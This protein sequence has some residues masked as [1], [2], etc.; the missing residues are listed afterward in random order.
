MAKQKRPR[1]RRSPLAAALRYPVLLFT[2]TLLLPTTRVIDKLGYTQRVLTVIG[3]QGQAY[4]RLTR[5]FGSYTPTR[6]DVIVCAYFKSGTNWAMQIAHQIATRGRGEFN[7]IHDVIPWPDEVKR[8]YSIPLEDEAPLRASPTGLRVIKTH[9]EW[10][11]VPYT[12]E[13]RYIWLLRDPKDVFVSSY[14]FIRDVLFGP[15]MPGVSDWLDFYLSSGFLMG[16]WTDH[17]QGY[18]RERHRSNILFL[19]FKEMKA[20]LPGCVGRIADFMGVEL[21][22]DEFDLVC[23]KSSFGYMK[24]IDHKFYPGILSPWSSDTGR[25]LR[26][27]RHGGSSELLA[28]EQQQRID[29]YCQDVLKRLQCDFPYDEFRV[30]AR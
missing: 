18:W 8:G 23:E 20:D 9:M 7:H 25:M 26:R 14:H 27:G 17:L 6:H 13:A 29:A 22:G 5:N 12:P 24:R 30:L 3:R 19:T 28:L 16:T 2:Y 10:E 4:L 11:Y 15:L 1:H 21:S